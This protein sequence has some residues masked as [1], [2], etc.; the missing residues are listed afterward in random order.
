MRSGGAY[1]PNVT[2]RY[3]PP[4]TPAQFAGYLPGMPTRA[5]ALRTWLDKTYPIQPGRSHA[6]DLLWVMGSV[7]TRH[8]TPAQQAAVYQVLSQ[9][10][11]LRIVPTAANLL[12]HTGVGIRWRLGRGRGKGSTYTLVFNRSTYQLLGMNWTGR[13]GMNGASGGE[14]V[15]KLAIVNKAGQLP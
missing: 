10:P 4:C 14:V 12:G 2:N 8:L 9:T 13:L 3:H 11:G 1:Y 6:I 7:L 15:V 5:A